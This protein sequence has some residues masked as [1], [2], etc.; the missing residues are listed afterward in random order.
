ML[1]AH[2][3]LPPTSVRRCLRIRVYSPCFRATLSPPFLAGGAVLPELLVRDSVGEAGSDVSLE[4][5]RRQKQRLCAPV[6]PCSCWRQDTVC[7]A[8]ASA[9]HS[10]CV[11]VRDCRDGCTALSNRFLFPAA[12]RAWKR[13][14][15]R[16][17]ICQ[18]QTLQ[19]RCT[20]RILRRWVR[21]RRCSTRRSDVC[22]TATRV[23]RAVWRRWWW[24]A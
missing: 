23:P 20:E 24:W 9:A 13:A 17:G 3:L 19:V 5:Q 8:A 14:D 1:L 10:C 21:W 12:Y 18:G 15:P 22:G 7:T 4:A 2:A 6:A 16:R 11:C